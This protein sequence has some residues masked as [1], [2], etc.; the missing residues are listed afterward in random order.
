M[1][2]DIISDIHLDFYVKD[3]K[4]DIENFIKALIKTKENNTFDVLII[5]G[6]IGHYNEDNIYFLKLISKYYKKV[7]VT[8]GNHDLY[9]IENQNEIYDFNSFNRLNELKEEIKHIDNVTFLDGQKIEYEGITFWGSGLWYEVDNIN[10]WANCMNDA[11]YIF[12]KKEGYKIVMPYD[13]YPTKFNFRTNKLYKS[14]YEKIKQ[15]DKADVIISHIPPIIFH[16]NRNKPNDY[17]YLPYG[18]EIIEK[19]K[20]KIWIFGHTHIKKE[21]N[22]KE[23]KLICDPLGYPNEN[24]NFRI[25]SVIIDKG[26]INV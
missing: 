4:K 23:C 17:Y 21:K 3:N 9:L 25:K 1:Q 12:D 18:E 14:E 16:F 6:D 19:I 20:P 10:H 22:F 26:Q 15:L 8:W 13:Y 24:R 11:R 2:L 5:A 7:F